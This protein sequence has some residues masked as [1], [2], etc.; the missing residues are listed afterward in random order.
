MTDLKAL[1]F[2]L[3]HEAQQSLRQDGHLTPTVV[4]IT[5]YENLIFDMEFETEE[6]RE[7]LYSEMLETAAQKSAQAIVTVN[8]VYLNE[9]AAGGLVQIAG[10]TSAS[11]NEPTTEA[12]V[13][14]VSGKG[15]GTWSLICPYLRG[16]EQFVFQPAL[17]KSTP[18][19]E[20]DL[21]GDWTGNSGS[22]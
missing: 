10:V 2:E 15:F 4:V 12:I 11:R 19:G 9:P 16:G 3:L 1:A 14:T 20:L 17:E 6:E 18:G 5:P 22:A 13:V 7:D 21:L 8:D